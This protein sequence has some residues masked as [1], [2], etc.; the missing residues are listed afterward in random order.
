MARYLDEPVDRLPFSSPEKRRRYDT[1]R[2]AGAIGLNWY[3][4]DP[5]LQFLMARYLG[6]DGLRWAD[7]HLDRIGRLMGGPIAR[8]AEETDRNPPRLEKYDRWG[9]D[10]SLVVMPPSFEQSRADLLADNFSSPAFADRARG[11][12]VDPAPLAAA[13]SYMLD[14][15][16]IGM[17]CALG[18]G[19][20]M[21]A[22]MAARFAPPDVKA[23]VAELLKDGDLG[24]EAAQL[25]TERTGGSDLAAIETTATPDGDA[26]KLNG[27]KWFASNAN[28]SVFVVLAKPEGAP[29][30][31]RGV[32]PFL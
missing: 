8:R 9:H 18:T 11:A 29:D 30:G 3:R 5:T 7:P 12:G 13:W 4:C 10:I 22:R 20:D 2:Y 16:E 6:D 28:G 21:V 31:T 25:F 19:G 24:G 23:V 32:A 14:Q 17:T 27:L 26:W 15:A 1:D